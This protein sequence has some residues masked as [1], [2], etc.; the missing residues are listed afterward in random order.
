MP[1][2]LAL[3]GAGASRVL[4][5]LTAGK[6]GEAVFVE[7]DALGTALEVVVLGT[8]LEGMGNIGAEL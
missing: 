3:H 6:V 4:L 7:V 8:I 5:G 2:L 1:S